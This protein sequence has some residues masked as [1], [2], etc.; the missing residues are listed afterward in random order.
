MHMKVKCARLS[1]PALKQAA[2]HS[3][4]K[5]SGLHVIICTIAQ[6]TILSIP[7]KWLQRTCERGHPP[8]N[9]GIQDES[10]SQEPSGLCLGRQ[11][12]NPQ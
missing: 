11:F 12:L 8:Q 2:S 10:D 9:E 5:P 7:G 6:H 3:F 4:S 1:R